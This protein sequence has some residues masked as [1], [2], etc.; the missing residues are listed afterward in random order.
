MSNRIANSAALIAMASSLNCLATASIAQNS[1]EPINIG[2]ISEL[3]G[4]WS[5]YGIQC[6]RAMQFAQKEINNAG[7]ALGRP[8]KFVTVDNQTNPA[9][10]VAAARSL[11]IQSKVVAYTGPTSSDTALA[12]QG[13]AEQ[14]KIPFIPPVASVPQLTKPG[15]KYTFRL[16]PDAIG[17]GYATAKFIESVKP[18][19]RIALIYSDFSLGRAYSTGIKY[20]APKSKLGIVSDI[21]LP[22]GTSDVT[23]QAA[24]IVAAAPDFIV[25]NTAGALE[26]TVTEQLINLGVKPQQIV[27]A[28]AFPATIEAWGSKSKGM[29]YGS[30]FDYNLEQFTPGG[31]EFAREYLAAYKQPPSHIENFCYTAPFVIKAA[32]DRA[33]STDR[34]KI[35]EAISSLEMTELFTPA[36]IKFDANGAR[37]EFLYV[38]QLQDV[39]PENLE[40]KSKQA[41][42]MEWDPEVI[43]VYELMKK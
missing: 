40:Y 23:I 14:N 12:I 36:P 9:Q 21:M 4:A 22:Q 7:G 28:F 41:F 39:L 6:E 33:G 10:A 42:Y 37:K 29:Y 34:E 11:D 25:T 19:A 18:D 26:V 8:L 38:M 35:R 15:T 16:Q 13:Y 43:P 24:Q 30:F 5:F 27:H 17:W 20:Y 31:K 32:I 2:F 3:S 1:K